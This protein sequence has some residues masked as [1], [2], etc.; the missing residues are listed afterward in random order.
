M[1]SRRFDM[2]DQDFLENIEKSG[3]DLQ[4]TVET[5]RAMPP[6][7]PPL[8]ESLFSEMRIA[9]WRITVRKE[10]DT[11]KAFVRATYMPQEQAEEIGKQAA[12][13]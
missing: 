10:G 13:T 4:E 1:C 3:L 12:L 7:S 8:F 9:V 2:M 5:G 11:T 6:P